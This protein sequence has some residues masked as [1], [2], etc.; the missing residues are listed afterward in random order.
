MQS[1]LPPIELGVQELGG[2]SGWL[3]VLGLERKT[4]TP[5]LKSL[6]LQCYAIF[7]PFFKGFLRNN[8][9]YPP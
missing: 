7:L 9:G 2:S 8:D 6:K 1:P 3:D 5:A 4:S